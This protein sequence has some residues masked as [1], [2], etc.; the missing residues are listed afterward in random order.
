MNDA[1]KNFFLLHVSDKMAMSSQQC[2]RRAI[3]EFDG[4]TGGGPG[5]HY[6]LKTPG[7]IDGGRKRIILT[8][9][10]NTPRQPQNVQD[11]S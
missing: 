4:N 11:R 6:H 1:E 2:S 5:W 7:K 8:L 9:W 10:L 3:R